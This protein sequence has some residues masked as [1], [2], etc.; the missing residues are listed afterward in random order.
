METRVEAQDR[1]LHRIPRR[2][3]KLS[4]LGGDL[5]IRKFERHGISVKASREVTLSGNYI[6][7]AT[8]VGPGGKGY[9][10]AVEGLADQHAGCL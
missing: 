5:G 9:G 10:I 8:G 6:S 4:G 2:A 7:E 3:V 1:D